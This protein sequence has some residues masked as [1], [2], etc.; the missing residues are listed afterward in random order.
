MTTL[1]KSIRILKKELKA[2]ITRE[3]WDEYAKEKGL[4][5]ALSI[6]IKFNLYAWDDLVIKLENR[7]Q[8]DWKMRED[9]G[10]YMYKK[11][12]E[13]QKK[14]DATI[15]EKG[16]KDIQVR[17]LSLKI[18]RMINKYYEQTETRHFTRN[19]ISNLYYAESYY[20]LRNYIIDTYTIP[21]Q[22]DWDKY[23]QEYGLMS[24][25]SL[26]YITQNTWEMLMDRI[27]R[28]TKMKIL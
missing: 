24:S 9:A 7:K 3:E 23:A 1:E 18:D 2:G 4:Y 16:L 14:L 13:N 8:R 27:K 6:L 11:I 28:E 22:S 26:C 15:E 17:K 10:K 21:S 20:Q 12:K 19:N 25:T 5:S